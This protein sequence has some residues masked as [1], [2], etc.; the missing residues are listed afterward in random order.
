M[1][2][3]RRI[4]LRRRITS[5]CCVLGQPG[6]AS[7]DWQHEGGVGEGAAYLELIDEHCDGVELIIRIRRVSHDERFRQWQCWPVG[8]RTVVWV[9]DGCWV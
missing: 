6:C 2:E 5:S 9:L 1:V 7:F 4:A 8:R 3:R